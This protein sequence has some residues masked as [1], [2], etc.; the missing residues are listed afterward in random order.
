MKF[1]LTEEYRITYDFNDTDYE[2]I[3]DED[4]MLELVYENYS[5][6][7]IKEILENN[8]SMPEEYYSPKKYDQEDIIDDLVRD[9]IF[10]FDDKCDFYN[11]FENSAREEFDEVDTYH[12]D[13]F[14]YNGVNQNDFI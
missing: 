10:L 14:G 8:I 4:E 5:I 7:E 11:Y 9:N 1:K 13:P 2:Y 12:K 6:E 3:P